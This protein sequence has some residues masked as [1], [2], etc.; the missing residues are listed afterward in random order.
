MTQPRL[1][2]CPR[3]GYKV[4]P[5]ALSGDTGLCASC[6]LIDLRRVIARDQVPTDEW[7]LFVAALKRA[8]RNG[9][10]HQRDMRPL[11][12]GRIEAKRIGQLYA[13]ARR[14]GLIREIGRERSNDTAGRNTNKVEPVY[15]L[16]SAA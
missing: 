4:L 11:L 12:H 2:P 14:E 1:Y 13:R 3:C 9:E 10:V 16:R 5:I 7:S 8:C 15:E 6:D